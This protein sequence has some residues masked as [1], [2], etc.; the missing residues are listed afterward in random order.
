MHFGPFSVAANSRLLFLLLLSPSGNN[1][2]SVFLVKLI[3]TAVLRILELC[4]ILLPACVYEESLASLS[5]L[6]I[7]TPAV[8]GALNMEFILKYLELYM[9][10]ILLHCLLRN[11]GKGII[12]LAQGLLLLNCNF[13]LITSY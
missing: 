12:Q 8:L 10:Y 2:F 11:Q 5:V 6:L 3:V 9:L 7:A 1:F 4:V 13:Q